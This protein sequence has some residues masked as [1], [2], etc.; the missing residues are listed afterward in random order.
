MS[1][2]KIALVEDIS[3]QFY[4]PLDL[5]L[6]WA[7]KF[8]SDFEIQ[9]ALGNHIKKYPLG[10]LKLQ[11]ELLNSYKNLGDCKAF[12]NYKRDI[13]KWLVGIPRSNSNFDIQNITIFEKEIS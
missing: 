4:K 8:G 13:Y 6:S 10:S 12:L 11:N 1:Q 3:G 9:N 2:Q 5:S 7:K